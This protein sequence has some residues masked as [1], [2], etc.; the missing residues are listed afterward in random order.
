VS[1]HSQSGTLDKVLPAFS[2]QGTRQPYLP[3]PITFVT[4]SVS[5]DEGQIHEISLSI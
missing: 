5:P 2:P 1:A 3:L 4:N